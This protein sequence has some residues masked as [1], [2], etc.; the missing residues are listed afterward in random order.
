MLQTNT[1]N[2][3]KKLIRKLQRINEKVKQNPLLFYGVT[4]HKLILISKEVHVM[5]HGL[6]R[7]GKLEQLKKIPIEN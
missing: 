5:G 4:G 2:E 7:E 6:L 1:I 3:L